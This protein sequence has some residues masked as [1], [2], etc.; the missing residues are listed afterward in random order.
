MDRKAT[1]FA[2]KVYAS[3]ILN[4]FYI[5]S[6]GFSYI[7]FIKSS[8]TWHK[9]ILYCKYFIYRYPHNITTK[10][11]PQQDTRKL[12]TFFKRPESSSHLKRNTSLS[13]PWG[14]LSA[15]RLL[16]C[17]TFGAIGFEPM[18]NG[19]CHD[20]FAMSCV[21]SMRQ[22][23]STPWESISQKRNKLAIAFCISST[24]IWPLCSNWPKNWGTR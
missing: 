19:M 2:S 16:F 17:L 23:T 7:P 18:F 8:S 20:L 9:W 24:C 13:S 22:L 3:E 1:Q 14:H 12:P 6:T 5:K 10:A 4:I 11:R 15:Q 21:I